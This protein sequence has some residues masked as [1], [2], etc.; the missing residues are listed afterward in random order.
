MKNL[1]NNFKGKLKK[2]QKKK[3]DGVDY[4]VEDGL[5]AR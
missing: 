5:C 4:R 1:E 2:I 3:Y